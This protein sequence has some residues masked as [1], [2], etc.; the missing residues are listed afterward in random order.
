VN[1]GTL[2][3]VG[4]AGALGTLLRHLVDTAVGSRVPG[5]FPVG[6]LAVNLSAALLLG[7]LAGLAAPTTTTLV[8]GVGLLGGYSTFSTWML[9][10]HRLAEDGARRLAALN[11][12]VP[13]TVG[14]LAVVLGRALGRLL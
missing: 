10:V 13:A 5:A 6:I 12:V 11:L 14:L 7:L 8:L 1:V 3:L 4:A 2:L 9:D